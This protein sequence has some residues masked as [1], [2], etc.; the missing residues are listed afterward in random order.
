MTTG[1]TSIFQSIFKGLDDRTLDTLRELAEIRTYPPQTVLC[2]QGA[3][4]H[5]FYV[6][7]EGRVA[8]AQELEDGQERLL[9]I[10]GPRQY[11]GAMQANQIQK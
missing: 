11:F 7:V 4:E 9:S 3:V 8:I 1:T 5:T 2:H 10:R 6:I